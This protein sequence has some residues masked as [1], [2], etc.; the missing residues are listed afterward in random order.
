MSI[1]LHYLF[2]QL[3]YQDK[4]IINKDIINKDKNIINKDKCSN[5]TIDETHNITHNVP[6]FKRNSF[7]KIHPFSKLI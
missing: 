6:T 4:D 5:I 1:D 3:S 2:S 7:G